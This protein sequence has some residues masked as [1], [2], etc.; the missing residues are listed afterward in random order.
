MECKHKVWNRD[1]STN[2]D[3]CIKCNSERDIPTTNKPIWA[4][5]DP[6]EKILDK[7]N[8]NHD[9]L[10]KWAINYKKDEVNR[11]NKLLDRFVKENDK[12]T[13]ENKEL[14]EKLQIV[15]N[16]NKENN[17]LKFQL[18]EL[19]QANVNFFNKSE[20]LKN[21]TSFWKESF[22]HSIKLKLDAERFSHNLSLGNQQLEIKIKD[23]TEQL[24]TKEIINQDLA[25]K[26]Q[27]LQEEIDAY[28]INM[29]E[30]VERHSK[31]EQDYKELQGKYNSLQEYAK[32][33]SNNLFKVNLQHRVKPYLS[34]GVI[35]VIV[36]SNKEFK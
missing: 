3:T 4:N 35:N 29:L 30:L 9:S 33:S 6:I 22:N 8:L 34:E 11:L 32:N 36:E 17:L 2:K 5:N 14:K 20:K 18:Q 26:Y 23:L 19:H 21:D 7:D 27:I 15:Q 12:L 10:N 16:S 25:K 24:E 1:L 28:D 13:E 31:L